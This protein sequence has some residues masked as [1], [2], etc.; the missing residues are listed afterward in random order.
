MGTLSAIPNFLDYYLKELNLMKGTRY[1][2]FTIFRL[3]PYMVVDGKYNTTNRV[4][5]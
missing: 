2:A 1:G 4:E 3:L 5:V